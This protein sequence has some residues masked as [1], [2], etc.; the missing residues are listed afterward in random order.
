[1]GKNWLSAGRVQTVALRLIVEREKEIRAFKI[2]DYLISFKAMLNDIQR[3]SHLLVRLKT[4]LLSSYTIS[5]NLSLSEALEKIVDATCETLS[6][7]RASVFMVDEL[8]GEL[9]TK[10]AKGSELTIRIPMNR[11]IVGY[12]VTHN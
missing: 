3:L 12:V 2:E 9:W 5:K 6:C 10:V 8:S 4:L 1:M 11:G 7:D